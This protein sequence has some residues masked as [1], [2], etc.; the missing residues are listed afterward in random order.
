MTGC[1]AQRAPQEIAA[2]DGVKWVIGNSHK[3]RLAEVLKGEGDR[4]EVSAAAGEHDFAVARKTASGVDMPAAAAHVLVGEID[5]EFHLHRPF[6][7]RT[8]CIRSWSST[9][10]PLM[11]RWVSSVATGC[12]R[13]GTRSD[14]TAGGRHAG[15]ADR[16]HSRPPVR[17]VD[18][19]LSEIVSRP[20]GQVRPGSGQA[21]AGAG[22][23]ER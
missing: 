14:P 12:T 8:I 1:Y 9:P 19:R 5:A 16:R 23:D 3:H 2:M 22:A 7:T 18:R 10:G 6:P 20:V 13:S 21:S 4:S 17:P 15:R 11:C